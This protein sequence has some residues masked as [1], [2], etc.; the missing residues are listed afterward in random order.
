VEIVVDVANVLGSR[1]DGWWRD[2]AGATTRLLAR[3]GGLPGTSVTVPG[4]ATSGDAQVD[5]VTV[6]LEGAARRADVPPEVVAVHAPGSGDDA[7]FAAVRER[8]DAGGD[9][10]VVTADRGLRGRLP[11]AVTIVGPD[12]LNRLIGR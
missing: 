5:V 8:V 11:E 12:W 2:R 4:R 7:I 9:V 10:V 3:I 6:V 1:A